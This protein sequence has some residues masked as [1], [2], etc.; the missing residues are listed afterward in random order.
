MAFFDQLGQK[1]TQTS[2]DAV[3]KTKDMA[4]VVRLNGVINEETKKIEA[5]YRELGKLYFERCADQAD[6]V[7]QP[8]VAEIQR[9]QTSI[10]EMKEAICQ[11]KGVR[12]CPSC[13]AELSAG[14]L[15]CTAC[16]AWMPAPPRP[17]GPVCPNCGAPVAPDTVFCTNCGVRMPESAPVPEAPQAR[18]PVCPSCGASLPEDTVFCTNCGT[19]IAAPEAD[20]PEEAEPAAE[21]APE[22]P[23]E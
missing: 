7:F 17:A 21:E 23:Q 5:G 1:L 19:R 3:K 9:A 4:E 16:G 15:F 18:G 8:Y 14:A 10:R 13:G 2:Q 22:M 20:T 11:L 12:L 6:P